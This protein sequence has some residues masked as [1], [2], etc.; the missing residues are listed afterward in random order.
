MSDRCNKTRV[1][2]P[3]NSQNIIFLCYH[4]FILYVHEMTLETSKH[5]N[6]MEVDLLEVLSERIHK[7]L[8]MSRQIQSC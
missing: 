1:D 6:K 3:G 5:E 2:I 8:A 7:N 4:L